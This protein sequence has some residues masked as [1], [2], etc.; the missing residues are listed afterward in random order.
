MAVAWRTARLLTSGRTIACLW[1]FRSSA[2]SLTPPLRCLRTTPARNFRL[3]LPQAA[4]PIVV[5]I[6]AKQAAKL[7]GI[8]TARFARRRYRR[9]SKEER[10]EFWRSVGR[11]KIKFLFL[12][13][14]SLSLAIGYGITHVE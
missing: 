11:H 6:A 14:I 10:A 5:V 7:V 9:W 2:S 3:S 1:F 8:L 13:A 12:T 4:P